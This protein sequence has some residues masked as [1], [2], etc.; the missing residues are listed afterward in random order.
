MNP[1]YERAKNS[2]KHVYWVGG[3]AAAGKTTICRR[4]CDRYGFIR[5][6]GDARWIEHWHSATPESHPIPHRIG[7]TMRDGGSLEWFFGRPARNIADDYVT[8]ARAEFQSAVD[9][10][11]QMPRDTP[12]VVDAFLGFPELILKVAHPENAVFLICTEEFMQR[13][14]TLR[15]SESAPGF[16]PILKRQLDTCTDPRSALDLFNES[17]KIQSRFI[18]DDCRR[19]SARLIVTGGRIDADEVYDAV[20]KHFRL[21]E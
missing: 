18:A 9:E 13:T 11:T 2:L 3:A 7:S 14:W 15:T 6:S 20:R 17:N 10:L 4:L 1:D 19:E 12:I 5:W 16:L 21:T 8:M